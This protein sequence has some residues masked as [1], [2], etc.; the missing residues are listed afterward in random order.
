M[1]K[2]IHAART[3]RKNQKICLVVQTAANQTSL[4]E[5]AQAAATTTAEALRPVK[6]K[7]AIGVD[8]MGSDNAPPVLLNALETLRSSLPP[9]VE[10]VPIGTP[11]YETQALSF[12]YQVAP[13][14]IGMDEHPLLALRRK[15][16]SSLCIGMRLLKEGRI[17]ALVS[18]G[19]TGALVTSA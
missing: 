7:L 17:Q 10:I 14:F 4:T 1:R 9:H 11:E 19:N 2:K 6:H 13:E 18:A 15:R 3:M 16:N 8:L 5:S 12:S